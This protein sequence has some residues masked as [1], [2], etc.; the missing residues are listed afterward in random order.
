VRAVLL[1]IAQSAETHQTRP[2]PRRATSGLY[3][4]WR[5]ASL[6]ESTQAQ[7]AE[8]EVQTRIAI[9]RH[10]CEAREGYLEHIGDGDDVFAEL[11]DGKLLGVLDLQHMTASHN[12]MPTLINHEHCTARDQRPTSISPRRLTFSFSASARLYLSCLLS[13][14][15]WDSTR[16]RRTVMSLIS[17]S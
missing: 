2:H 14:M 8:G 12:H 6:R 3:C 9:S 13:E 7:P 17:A 5:S 10:E 1:S 15:G 16:C 4:P 11:L